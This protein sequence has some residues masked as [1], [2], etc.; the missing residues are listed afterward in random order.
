MRPTLTLIINGKESE[1]D[2]LADLQAALSATEG[3]QFRE[4]WISRG[5]SPAICALLNGDIGWLMYLQILGDPS[6][7]SRNPDYDGD[8]D[9]VTEYQL[10][11]GQMDRYPTSWALPKAEIYAALA[12]FLEHRERSPLVQWHDDG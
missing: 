8:P 10:P 1:I 9:A 4:V 11:S 6:F 2:R 7:S 5:E 3:T 12:H